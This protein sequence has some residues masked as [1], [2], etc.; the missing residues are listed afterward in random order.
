MSGL[1]KNRYRNTTISFRVTPDER[2]QLEARI[3]VCGMPKGEYFIQSLLHQEVK[4]VVGKYQ[5][6]RF[7]LELRRL[8]EQLENH[9]VG[10]EKHLDLL[11]DCKALLIELHQIV[12]EN[13]T[14][15]LKL[16]DFA[17]LENGGVS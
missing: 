12:V 15:E 5:S 16:S 2:K 6:D 9:S 17:T 11:E 14:E 13:K 10:D 1:D 7:S 3:K 8:R 4:I